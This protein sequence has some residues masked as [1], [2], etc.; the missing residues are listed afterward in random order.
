MR[1]TS[2]A[3][4]DRSGRVS[5]LPSTAVWP[6]VWTRWTTSSTTSTRS[7]S[8]GSGGTRNGTPAAAIFCL[9]RVMRAATAVSFSSRPAA[10][11]ATERPATSRNVNATWASRESAGWAQVNMSRSRSVPGSASSASSSMTSSGSLRRSVASRRIRSIARWRAVVVS[12]AAG[13]RGGSSRQ[14]ARARTKASCTQ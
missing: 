7:G 6:A 1:A 5:T 4:P 10:I 14:Q 2:R 12:H 9:A 11:S 13:L 8:S 3:L